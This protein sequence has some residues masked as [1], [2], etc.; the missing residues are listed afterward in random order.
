MHSYHGYNHGNESFVFD[1]SHKVKM[2]LVH[3]RLQVNYF[4][5]PRKIP[6]EKKFSS[7][8][9]SRSIALNHFFIFKVQN[10]DQRKSNPSMVF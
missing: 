10:E 4:L 9:K 3:F 7:L 6:E 2:Q 5:L 8:V 1:T